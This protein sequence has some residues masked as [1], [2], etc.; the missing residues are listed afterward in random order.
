MAASIV[1][2]LIFFLPRKQFCS[3]KISLAGAIGYCTLLYKDELKGTGVKGRE[4]HGVF[5]VGAHV[6]H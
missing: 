2:K 3:G 1:V 4:W 5:C 6:G